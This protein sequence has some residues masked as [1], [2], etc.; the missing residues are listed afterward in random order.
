MKR[1]VII[2][3]AL[4]IGVFWGIE[5]NVEM[6]EAKDEPTE[7]VAEEEQ[8][9]EQ[10]VVEESDQ[11]KERYEDYFTYYMEELE[12]LEQD[13]W[14]FYEPIIA[15]G[16]LERWDEEFRNELGD[17]S[18][19]LI[20]LSDKIEKLSPPPEYASK[21]AMLLDGLEMYSGPYL[22]MEF[23]LISVAS[24]KEKVNPGLPEIYQQLMD[25]QSKIPREL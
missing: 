14:L 19:R 17:L 8:E 18:T 5:S 2:G 4:A 11:Q 23:K 1:N 12:E 7:V 9:P 24:G 22:R 13:T 16:E 15:T 25:A 3:V 21:H 10:D 6:P 20:S